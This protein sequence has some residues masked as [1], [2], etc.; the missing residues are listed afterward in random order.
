MVLLSRKEVRI[1]LGAQLMWFSV[2]FYRT[3]KPNPSTYEATMEALRSRLIQERD[4]CFVKRDVL[5]AGEEVAT[6]HLLGF[7]LSP[8]ECTGCIG[9]LEACLAECGDDQID[10]DIHLGT[11]DR[12]DVEQLLAKFL[13]LRKPVDPEE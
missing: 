11:R 5:E 6:P 10:L 8:E 13:A 7:S 1:L 12:Q 3:T 9:A 2:P 4:A